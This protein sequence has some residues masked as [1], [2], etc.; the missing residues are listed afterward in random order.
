M[1]APTDLI[2]SIVAAKTEPHMH[3]QN[4]DAPLCSLHDRPRGSHHSGQESFETAT[5]RQRDLR[6]HTSDTKRRFSVTPQ[7]S[8]R[9]V[10]SLHE[11]TS[12]S[13]VGAAHR[14]GVLRWKCHLRERKKRC[15]NDVTATPSCSARRIHCKRRCALCNTTTLPQP[16]PAS[17]KKPLRALRALLCSAITLLSAHS[18]SP[19]PHAIVAER[20]LRIGSHPYPT[21][22]G[23]RYASGS[24]FSESRSF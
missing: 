10:P 17:S 19:P 24:V 20:R 12:W 2:A 4:G 22:A 6:W 15:S 21:S 8:S 16:P 7:S 3:E 18:L 9:F 13:S 14:S 11:S 1:S 23:F 5:K